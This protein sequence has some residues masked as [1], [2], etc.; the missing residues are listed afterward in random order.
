MFGNIEPL[1]LFSWTAMGDWLLELF[2]DSICS[3]NCFCCARWLIAL[4]FCNFLRSSI[5]ESGFTL[6]VFEAIWAGVLLIVDIFVLSG[7]FT[8]VYFSPLPNVLVWFSY[9]SIGAPPFEL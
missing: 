6:L 3:F 5:V 2:A 7:C 4:S 8:I 1:T 9:L